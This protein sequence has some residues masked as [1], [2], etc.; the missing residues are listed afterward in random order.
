MSWIASDIDL[1]NDILVSIVVGDISS[2][3]NNQESCFFIRI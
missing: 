1:E 2:S 3:K